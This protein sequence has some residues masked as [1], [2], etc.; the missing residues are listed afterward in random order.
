VPNTLSGN[1]EEENVR[2]RFVDIKDFEPSRLP[3]KYRN[4]RHAGD[5]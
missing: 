1:G 3:G 5:A 2:L 4:P